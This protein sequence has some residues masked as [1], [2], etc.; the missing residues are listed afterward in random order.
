MTNRGL[1]VGG[2]GHAAGFL[3]LAWKRVWAALAIAAGLVGGLW[4]LGWFSPLS[5]W[6]PES[7][8]AAGLA[9]I[10]AQA[11]LYRLALGAGRLGPAGLQW[12]APEWRLCAVWVLTA[13]FLFVLGLLGF[14]VLL[15]FAFAVASSGHG[16]IVALPSTW[17]RAVDDRGRA[18]VAVVASAV[19]AGVVWASVKICLASA[20]SVARGRLQVLASW[21][22]TRRLVAPL[23]VSRLLLA[24]VPAGLGAAV[25]W[26]VPAGMAESGPMAWAGRLAAG[27]AIAGLWL[28]M[29]VGLMAYFYRRSATPRPEAPS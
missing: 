20:A 16:F 8:L 24:L 6:R 18:V 25:L 19:L 14:V 11:G 13:V 1:I 22:D 5:P 9:V 3:R 12:R 10:M 28:P 21:P 7:L 17:A 4:A 27:A 15:A 23:L 26:G 29:N 2:M